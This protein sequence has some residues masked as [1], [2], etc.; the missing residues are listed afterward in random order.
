M[1]RSVILISVIIPLCGYA[2]NYPLYG[3]GVGCGYSAARGQ[4]IVNS[5]IFAGGGGDGFDLA[6]NSSL[7]PMVSFSGGAG[8][9]VAESEGRNLQSGITYNGGAGDGFEQGVGASLLNNT[10]FAGGAGDGYDNA[11]NS[12]YEPAMVFGGGDG[13]GY[14][15]RDAEIAFS[16]VRLIVF[17]EGPLDT[18]SGLMHDD[19]RFLALIPYNE[20]FTGIGFPAASNGSR[21]MDPIIQSTV[22]SDAIVD[23]IRVEVRSQTDSTKIIESVNGL[24]QRDGDVVDLDGVSPLLLSV[25]P[26]DHYLVIRPR[27]HLCIMTALPVTLDCLGRTVDLTLNS[28]DSFGVEAQKKMGP[29]QAMWAGDVNADGKLKYVGINNDR[30]PILV[31]I[32]GNVPTNTVNG[33]YSEDVNMDGIVK[34]TGMANDRDLILVNIGGSVPTN[35]RDKQVP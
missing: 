8:D 15:D 27:N 31:S 22:G 10:L 5:N 33:Y 35:V 21:V 16:S 2:Q 7:H 20:P 13:D 1:M 4:F 12:N 26:G 3:G 6:S 28:S 30:D 29:Y 23:W 18:I 17:L 11:G 14:A 9:G 19:L 34:Y 32:G 24:I 25:A